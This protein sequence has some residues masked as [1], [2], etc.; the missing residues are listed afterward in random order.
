VGRETEKNKE[1]KRCGSE[2]EKTKWRR[3][4]EKSKKTRFLQ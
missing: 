1:V 4:R 2:W 3:G